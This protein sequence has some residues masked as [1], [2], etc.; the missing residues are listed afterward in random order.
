MR[1]KI[2]FIFLLSAAF[3]I[4]CSAQNNCYPNIVGV[5]EEQ[6][7]FLSALMAQKRM[8]R[9]NENK[10]VDV[11]V[12]NAEKVDYDFFGS[13]NYALNLQV[14]PAT[15]TFSNLSVLIFQ[16]KGGFEFAI[17][18]FENNILEYNTILGMTNRLNKI[19]NL[20]NPKIAVFDDNEPQET[21]D[22]GGFIV[23]GSKRFTQLISKALRKLEQYTPNLY[24][25]FI[26][27]N[28]Y[29]HLKG[30][31]IECEYGGV[32]HPND[33]GFIEISISDDSSYKDYDA[34]IVKLASVILHEAVH[35]RQS[36]D[37]IQLNS[38]SCFQ[39]WNYYRASDLTIAQR[40]EREAFAFQHLFFL[41]V[42]NDCNCQTNLAIYW[43]WMNG[44]SNSSYPD[45]DG[46]GMHTNADT[47]LL[48]SF[49]PK[50]QNKECIKFEEARLKALLKDK[51]QD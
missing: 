6:Q 39:S 31:K 30:I 37:Y 12:Y 14:K 41:K 50:S 11:F 47:P 15:I 2:C 27:S 9:F 19:L 16:T 36:Y 46:D 7:D 24:A 20:C 4:T 44:L 33:N 34:C 43:C 1:L 3:S 48:K 40:C 8:F 51:K 42:Y 13:G 35:L 38:N 28:A 5:W 25:N 32:N 21:V 23:F 22:E 10:T 29:T 45:V 18:K 26:H 49:H 17:Q